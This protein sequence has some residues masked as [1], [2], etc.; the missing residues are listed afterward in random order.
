MQLPALSYKIKY[1]SEHLYLFLQNIE[2][3]FKKLN[4]FSKTEMKLLVFLSTKDEELYERQISE[5]TEV[6]VGSVNTILKTFVEMDLVKKTK[7]GRMLFYRR[8]DNNPLLRQFKVFITINNIMPLIGKIIPLSRRI[9]IFGSC[10]EGT[11]GEDSDVDLFVLS[12]EKEK[13]RRILDRYPKVQAI[14]LNSVEFADLRKKDK[15][16][17]DRIQKG[18]EIYGGQ[19]G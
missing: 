5:E 2:L 16:L 9:I 19:D 8:N 3:M 11:N 18:I 15:P 4:L 6:S 13:I 10:A 17:Y 1:E 12:R 14:L 7:K